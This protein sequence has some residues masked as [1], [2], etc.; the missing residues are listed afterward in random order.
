MSSINALLNHGA[1][2]RRPSLDPL[3][4]PRDAADALTTL[5]TLGSGQQYAAP[6]S[7]VS[8]STAT[9]ASTHA[10]SP[11]AR[12]PSVAHAPVEPAPT[13]P[14]AARS[15]SLAHY[16]HAQHSPEERRRRQSLLTDP[17]PVLAPML[18]PADRVKH[19]D[20]TDRV[21]HED[22]TDRVKHKPHMEDQDASA[23]KDEHTVTDEHTREASPASHPAQPSPASLNDSN[24]LD[25]DTL[26]AIEAAKA[27]LGL[28]AK[29][30]ASVADSVSPKPSKKR[31]A[32]SAVKKKGTAKT[33]PSKK[34]RIDDER[35]VTPTRRKKGSQAGTP[36]P[37]SPAPDDD[38]HD[39]D[40]SSEDHNLYCICKKPDNHK[41]MIGCDGGCDDWF[42][43]DCVSM[44]QADEHLVDKFICPLCE[45]AGKGHTTWKPMCR[46]DACRRPARPA[47]TSKYCSDDCG[48]LFM[49][50]QLQRT[51]GAKPKKKKPAHDDDEPTPL[52]GVLRAKDLKALVSA[53]PNIAAFRALGSGVLSPP[54]TAS[55][56]RPDFPPD[57]LTPAETLRLTA[58]HN[59]KS[60]LNDRLQLLKD[61]ER[62]VSQAKERAARAAEREKVKP[63]DFCG[64]DAR[65]A[66][67]DAEFLAWRDSAAGC[68]AFTS[69]STPDPTA[70]QDPA[71]QDEEDIPL[72]MKK[73]CAKHPAWQKLNLQDARFEELEVVEA[74]RECEKEERSVRERARRRGV[75]EGMARE[76]TGGEGRRGEGWVEVV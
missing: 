16:H 50:E 56:T 64:Y 69:S 38:D 11:P 62:F 46:R 59:E 5:A 47:D 75:K 3:Q 53:S 13:D 61:R 40:D 71:A 39:D 29:R 4:P 41:W 67:S 27:D 60:Q 65:L 17:A 57:A 63:K 48:V 49:Q 12:R 45:A 72:C 74:I 44:K 20:P 55:P 9:P 26:K 37:S 58:L 73:R 42:H 34:R 24:T 14:P 6:E 54:P 8:A 2:E 32:P 18:E 33:K 21:K 36:L 70:M 76:I 51:A 15:P 7:T 28:R 43:G 19:E 23:V 22:P 30:P 68:A 35:S 52:G 25:A 10:A 1:P 66:W 31:P